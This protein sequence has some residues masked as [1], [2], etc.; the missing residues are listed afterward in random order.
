MLFHRGT[1]LTSNFKVNMVM[2]KSS[3]NEMTLFPF[4]WTSDRNFHHVFKYFGS[5][6]LMIIDFSLNLYYYAKKTVNSQSDVFLKE[7]GSSTFKVNF[8]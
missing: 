1:R 8:C 4:V 6:D 5:D 7:I 3:E 2:R